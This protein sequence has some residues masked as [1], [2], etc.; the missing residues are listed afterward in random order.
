MVVSQ[1]NF[2]VFVA[3][4]SQIPNVLQEIGRLREQTFRDISE[5]TGRALDIDEFDLYYHQLIIW[6][7]NAERIVGGYRIGCGDEIFKNYGKHGFYIS[8]LFKIKVGF[9]PILQRSLELGR[10]FIVFDYQRK[11]LPL[12]LLWKG[13]LAFLLQNPQYRYLFGPVS[14][15]RQFSNVSRSLVV[16]FLKT[17]YFNAELAVYLKPRKP[18]KIPKG[19]VDTKLLVKTFGGDL[20]N[21][22]KFIEGIETEQLRMPVL[23]RQYIRQNARFVGFNIDPKF[24]DCLDGFIILNLKDIPKNTIENLQRTKTPVE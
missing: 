10:S 18:F 23:M 13:I 4:A 11:P 16:D 5:G 7:R 6:D 21:L 24:S 12:F 3:A 19:K 14:M 8:T 22:D 2:D 15:S 1:S 9:Y 20:G 17:H